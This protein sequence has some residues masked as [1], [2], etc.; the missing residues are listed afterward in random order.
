[1]SCNI[2]G[3]SALYHNSACCLLQDGKLKIAV[4]EERFTRIKHDFSMPCNA[5]RYCLQKEGLSVEDI[6]VVAYY[7]EP[8]IKLDRQQ[9]SGFKATDKEMQYILDPERP[10]KEIRTLLGYDGPVKFY[11]HH[12]SHA[13]SAYYYSN[14]NDAA[15][16]TVDGVGEWATTTYG[17]GNAGKISNIDEVNFPHSIGLLYAAITSF[18]GFKVNSG[19]YKVMGLAPY[20]DLSFVD[21]IHTLIRLESGGQY[22]LA[23]EYFD[24]INGETMFSDKL[25]DLLG[26][27]PRTP[28]TEINREHMNIARSLQF[29]LEEILINITNWL[30]EKTKSPNL[31]MA[32]GV[33]LNCV[34]NGFLY[35]NSKFKN[36]F[37]QPAANDAGGAI[38]AA[39]LSYYEMTGN[40]V[41]ALRDAYLG[42]SY[43]NRQ[44]EKVITKTSLEYENYQEDLDGFIKRCASLLADHKVMGWFQGNMEFGARAL[45]N[46]SILA[47]PRDATM[48]DRINS[49]VKK[50]ESFRPFAPAVLEDCASD[51]F[52]MNIPS[53]FMLFTC[54]VT[55]NIDMPAITHVNNSA[56]IQTVSRDTNDMFYKLINEFYR[57]T[58]CPVLLNTSFNVR[59]EPIVMDVK[60]AFKCFLNTKIDYLVIGRYIVKRD[61]S[62]SR[63]YKFCE[64]V[65]EETIKHKATKSSKVYTFL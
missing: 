13:A 29:V 43:T 53:P 19:E 23:L 16:L 4:E 58:G 8:N 12:M 32:G 7:E 6:D 34:A 17:Y 57:I 44:I 33:A 27:P 60:D 2:I 25:I 37:V 54:D 47:D 52:N 26:I 10:E 64:S 65:A 9:W 56:R 63:R 18:L 51:H 48:R 36:I 46:R 20:G 39:A 55:S 14:F 3:I 50:R 1:M 31:C 59:G 38:G 15:I 41:Q 11:N 35:R 49:M 40:R 5:F 62:Y 21:K 28:E 45:G 42:P 24:F 22:S 61:I 30:Y